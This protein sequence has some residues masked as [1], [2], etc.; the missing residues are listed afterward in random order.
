LF[1]FIGAL[2]KAKAGKSQAFGYS[3]FSRHSSNGKARIGNMYIGTWCSCFM[4]QFF[5]RRASFHAPEEAVKYVAK[6]LSEELE[7]FS[8]KDIAGLAAKLEEQYIAKEYEAT[9]LAHR[10]FDPIGGLISLKTKLGSLMEIRIQAC[11][12]EQCL[13]GR[14]SGSTSVLKIRSTLVNWQSAHGS[15][16]N[17][18]KKELCGRAV[19]LRYSWDPNLKQFTPRPGIK[20]LILVV[21]GTWRQEDLNALASAGW[22]EIFY[23]DE[24]EKLAKAIV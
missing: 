3:T 12:A 9:L 5:S 19:G 13:D 17:D 21:D 24:M 4:N 8:A 10:G 23:P 2:A 1:D 20:K 6:I 11:F 14:G 15:H 22:D 16:T 7:K 18:K